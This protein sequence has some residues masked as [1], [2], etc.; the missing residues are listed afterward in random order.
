MNK[1]NPLKVG[2][3]G[4]GARGFNILGM[5]LKMEDVEILAVCEKREDHLE[6]ARQ[7]VAECKKQ[8]S[9]TLFTTDYRDMLKIDEIQAVFNTASW[10]D[11][12][13]IVIEAM[14]AGKD[15]AFE[16]GGAHSIRECWNL[17]EAQQR[18]GRK[19]MMLENCCYGR[20]ELAALSMARKGLFGEI[21]HCTGG[22]GHDQ[23]GAISCMVENGR[24]RLPN[25]IHR[26]GDNYPTH[27]LGPIA[28]ILDINRGNRMVS[29]VSVASKA[30]GV[31]D[32]IQ[33]N[34]DADHPLQGQKFRQGDVI[35]TIITCAHGETIA[36]TLDTGIPRPYSRHF[37]IFGTKGLYDEDGRCFYFTEGSVEAELKECLGNED[38]YFE[39]HDHPIWVEKRN[40]P[41]KP[42]EAHGGMDALVLQ[43]FVDSVRFDLPTP[44]DV[45]DAAAWMCI[46]TLSEESVSMGG[47][48]VAIPDFTNGRWITNKFEQNNKWSI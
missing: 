7:A 17:V 46:T 27:A 33:R 2:I 21:V 13:Q 32:Y 19:C 11:H 5:L 9:P 22:Y 3:V 15:V 23:R 18:T 10:A 31:A 28:K 37:G 30:V 20:M 1:Q 41:L 45:Y 35:S 29:L 26:N 4:I 34:C 14:E 47:A 48:P 8:D 44:I 42:G 25:Y 12:T 16:V 39:E 40:Q 38:S 24:Y 43:A 36:L 6:K